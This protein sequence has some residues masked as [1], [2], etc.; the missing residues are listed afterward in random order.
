MSINLKYISSYPED[1]QRQVEKLI[2]QEKLKDFLL[3]KYPMPHHIGNDNQLREF[4][5]AIKNHFLKKSQPL[6][7]VCF[8]GKIHVINNALGLHSYVTRAHGGKLK[9]KNEIRVASMF[10][11][12]PLEFLQMIVVHEL[13]H[14]KEREHNKAFYKLCEHMLPNYHQLEF[15]L[16]LYLT[17]VEHDGPLYKISSN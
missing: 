6:S 14:L 17:Q 7:K 12:T 4:T 10:K 13:A 15:D 9:S 11:N 3:N 5:I 2:K 1:I 8:D 16:R